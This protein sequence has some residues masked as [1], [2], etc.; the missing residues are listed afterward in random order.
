[1]DLFDVVVAKKLSGGGSGGGGSSDFSTAQVTLI[2]RGTYFYRIPCIL[3]NAEYDVHGSACTDYFDS[4]TLTA[5]LYKGKAY[6]EFS[7]LEVDSISG[8]IEFDEG[9]QMYVITGDCTITFA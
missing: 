9:G 5:I 4:S 3:D 1:M 7:P 8:N 2:N 6:A